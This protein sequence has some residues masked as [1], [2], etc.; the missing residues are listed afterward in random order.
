MKKLLGLVAALALLVSVGTAN[1][2]VLKNFKFGGSVEMN[3]ASARFTNTFKKSTNGQTINDRVGTGQTRIMLN[4][5]WDLLDDVHSKITLRKNNR[6]YGNASERISGGANGVE[7]NVWLDQGYFKIDKVFGAV[8]MTFGR[9]FYGEPGDL[10]AYY[11]PK[12]NQYGMTVTAIDG[13]RFDWSG[14]KAYATAVVF[15]PTANGDALGVSANGKVDIRGFIAG[16]KGH[17]NIDA[18][19]Y[20]WNQV[21]H[22]INTVGVPAGTYTQNRNLW[23]PG[24]KVKAKFGGLY[25]SLEA[26]LNM[27]EDRQNSGGFKGKAILANVGMKADVEQIGT[28]NPWAEFAYGSG[29]GNAANLKHNMDFTPIASDYRPGAI[30]G[31][32]D[33]GSALPLAGGVATQTNPAANGLTNRIIWGAGVKA[34]PKAQEKLTAGL[35]FYDFNIQNLG[36]GTGVNAGNRHIG[37]E[38][39]VTAEWK[40]SE[41]VSLKGT[42]GNF[43]PGGYLRNSIE[44]VGYAANG[45]PAASADNGHVSAAWLSALDVMVKF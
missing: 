26:A 14:E 43:Q 28:F 21:T 19:V 27:G 34:T 30:Y 9:Q 8:D 32:F 22:G 39:D 42:V 36:P 7:E 13:A 15:E 37:S 45:A 29:N 20:V 24:F 1:A 25:G 23:V 11:G 35:N 6:V 4:M 16:N 41:N 18:K 3:A 5:D 33:L 40:H 44:H 10:I 12:Y 2:E 17:E 31:R 38:V